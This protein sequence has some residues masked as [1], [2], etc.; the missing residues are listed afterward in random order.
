[1]KEAKSEC[2][3]H[4][5]DCHDAS[6]DQ[7]MMAELAVEYDDPYAVFEYVKMSKQFVVPVIKRDRVSALVV[8]SISIETPEGTSPLILEREP[9]LRDGFLQV[10][11]AHANSGGFD[12]AFTT[13]QS[14]RDLRGSLKEAARRITGV[15]VRSVLIEEIVKQQM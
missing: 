6:A 3:P 2:D 14:M 8:V 10:L 11:F 12:G 9:K 4:D 1:M 13:G 5:L 15:D 7:V